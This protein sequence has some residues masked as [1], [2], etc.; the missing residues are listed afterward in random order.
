M[1]QG[2]RAAIG[3]WVSLSEASAQEKDLESATATATATTGHKKGELLICHRDT[4][5]QPLF[6]QLSFFFFASL[7]KTESAL[8]LIFYREESPEV[9]LLT[10]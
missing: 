9:F 6:L 5:L 10:E 8:H 2:L 3:R 7:G 1:V 4:S